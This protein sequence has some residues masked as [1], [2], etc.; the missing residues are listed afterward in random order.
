[1]DVSIEQA[2]FAAYFTARGYR[3]VVQ[4][5]RGKFRSEGETLLFVNEAYDGHDTLDWIIAQPWSDGRV[6]MFGDSYYGFTQWAA[7]STSHQLSQWRSKGCADSGRRAGRALTS[8]RLA[9]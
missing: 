8:G 2:Q 4:D 1:M 7:A 9:H 3:M 5:V 6:G